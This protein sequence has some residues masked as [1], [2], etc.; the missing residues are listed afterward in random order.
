MVV[1]YDLAAA[2]VKVTG[3]VQL[4]PGATEFAQLPSATPNALSDELM[5]ASFMDSDLLV[6]VSVTDAWATVAFA[7]WVPKS[8]A[9]G[10]MVITGVWGIPVPVRARVCAV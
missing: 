4:A 10:A 9:A 1:L 7:I 6:L 2:G 8:S 5:E 3:R